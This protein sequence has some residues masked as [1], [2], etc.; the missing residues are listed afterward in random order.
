[1]T[2][3]AARVRNITDKFVAWTRGYHA[4]VALT[5]GYGHPRR[6]RR[7]VRPPRAEENSDFRIQISD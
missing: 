5:H 7:A 2:L 1:V 3:G 4:G 6:G